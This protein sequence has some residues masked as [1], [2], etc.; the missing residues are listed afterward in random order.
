M[1]PLWP[2]MVEPSAEAAMT[3]SENCWLESVGRKLTEFWE[4]S[5][6]KM[7]VGPLPMTMEPSDETAEAEVALR[8]GASWGGEVPTHLAARVPT[9]PTATEPSNEDAATPALS[10]ELLGFGSSTTPAAVILAGCGNV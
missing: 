3:V 8:S 6:R 9:E 2:M 1:P 4:V 5:H 7:P 10:V